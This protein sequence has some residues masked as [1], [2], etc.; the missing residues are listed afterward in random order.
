MA[1]NK[2]TSIRTTIVLSNR[3]I[4]GIDRAIELGYSLNQSDFIRFAISEKLS[5]LS[6]IDN[7]KKRKA[8]E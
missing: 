7:M 5:D 6:I 4:E 8:K 1:E 3:M 2:K